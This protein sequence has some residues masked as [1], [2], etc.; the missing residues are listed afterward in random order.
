M[1]EAPL[2]QL[3]LKE[4][5]TSGSAARAPETMVHPGTQRLETTPE[6]ILGAQVA[7]T[8]TLGSQQTFHASSPHFDQEFAEHV[9]E[10]MGLY[11]SRNQDL[12]TSS[13]LPP[14]MNGDITVAEVCEA[15]AKLK[16]GKAASPVSGIPSELLKYGGC[17]QHACSCHSSPASGR[18]ATP[19]SPG[20]R[21]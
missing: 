19:P 18:Q 16:N 8:R 14:C 10:Q 11:A 7:H 20:S 4:L 13:A 2:W 9:T 5:N 3:L 17:R 12:C 1:G 15:L 6:G 21:A